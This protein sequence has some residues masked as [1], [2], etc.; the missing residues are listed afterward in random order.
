MNELTAAILREQLKK[1]DGVVREIRKRNARVRRGIEDIKAIKFRRSN[2]EHG[3]SGISLVFFVESRAKARLF[4]DALVAENIR[5]TSGGYPTVVYDPRV[6]DGHTFMHWGHIIKDMK[7]NIREHAKSLDLM[8]RA[9]H[10][11]ISP[12]LTDADVDDVVEAVRK[13]SAAVL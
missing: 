11:D 7:K 3:E 10:L 8:T 6:T 13:V 1:M 5:T 12:L 4:K 9:V 2:D